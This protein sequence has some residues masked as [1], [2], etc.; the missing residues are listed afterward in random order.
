MRTYSLQQ[1]LFICSYWITCWLSS[2]F[3]L[4]WA[5]KYTLGR[6]LPSIRF[7]HMVEVEARGELFSSASAAFSLTSSLERFS[8]GVVGV[9]WGECP[10]QPAESRATKSLSSDVTYPEKPCLLFSS[11]EVHFFCSFKIRFYFWI[12]KIFLVLYVCS[13]FCVCIFMCVR[14]YVYKCI[15]VWV[16][17]GVLTYA[18]ARG[19]CQ[20]SSLMPI[21]LF[22]IFF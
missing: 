14:V 4:K 13:D 22:I 17:M 1:S 20:D 16:H 10:W 21:H 5:I 12:K 9:G 2:S 11:K 3:Y 8:L 18:E 6:W 15:C 19:H 7:T